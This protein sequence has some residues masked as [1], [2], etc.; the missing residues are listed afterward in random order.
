M[1]VTVYLNGVI[2]PEEKICEL[3]IMNKEL[4]D[5]FRTVK[6]RVQKGYASK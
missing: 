2:I 1:T 5:L 6:E 4:A 3:Q